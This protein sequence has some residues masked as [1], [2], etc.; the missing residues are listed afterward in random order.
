MV[1]GRVPVLSISCLVSSSP[2]EGG[3]RT[4]EVRMIGVVG[5]CRDSVARTSTIMRWE[6]SLL[7]A[8]WNTFKGVGA[9]L[10]TI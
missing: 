6:G 1:G 5:E 9:A 10:V 8:T 7:L 4:K 2:A 3:K